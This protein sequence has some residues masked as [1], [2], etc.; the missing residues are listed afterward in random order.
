[1]DHNVNNLNFYSSML[2]NSMSSHNERPKRISRKNA[3]T[4]NH[5]LQYKCEGCGKL[6]FS[7]ASIIRHRLSCHRI[8]HTCT[9]CSSPLSARETPKSHLQKVH[10]IKNPLACRCCPYYYINKHDL[11]VHK[12]GGI[13]QPAII[14]TIKSSTIGQCL[15]GNNGAGRYGEDPTF[16]DFL[17][18]RKQNARKSRLL[19]S[20]DT[21]QPSREPTKVRSFMIK[22]ILNLCD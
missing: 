3:S 7:R 5:I 12:S 21:N 4:N 18:I 16:R 15:N 10:G 17:M 1:M 11:N 2:A 13:V 9:L 6:Y 22:D 14:I 20:K 8:A 19:V